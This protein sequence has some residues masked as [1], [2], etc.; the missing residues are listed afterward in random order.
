MGKLTLRNLDMVTA[1]QNNGILV[2]LTHPPRVL[3]D[4]AVWQMKTF[5]LSLL[6]KR[7]N[8]WWKGLPGRWWDGQSY[9][10]VVAAL[11]DDMW[12]PL[13]RDTHEWIDNKIKMEGMQ[14]VKQILSEQLIFDNVNTNG[15]N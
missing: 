10:Q 5:S 2:K 1:G 4:E 11:A 9:D 3:L 6:A 15:L 13:E 14:Q 7:N 12:E 8:P